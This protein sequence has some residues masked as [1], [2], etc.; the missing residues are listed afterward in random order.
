MDSR[1][2]GNPQS[3]RHST[4]RLNR[5]VALC[6]CFSMGIAGEVR[7]ADAAPAGSGAAHAATLEILEFYI[8]GNSVLDETSIDEAVEPFLGPDRTADDVD[9][10]RAALEAAY[11]DRG[12]KTVSVA[13]PRQSV[14]DG[15]IHLQV[16]EG[17]V[18][19]LDVV[20]S[21][22]HSIERI[23]EQAPALAEGG[24]PNFNDVQRDLVALNQEADRRVTPTL[25]AGA[26]PGTVDMEL[27]VDDHLPLHGLAEVNN[28]KSIGTSELRSTG[29]LSYDNLWQR[30]H[31]FSLTYQTA[32]ERQ[33]DARVLFGS[34]LAHFD[35]SPL[36]LLLNGLKTD[37]NVATLG[38]VDV[39]GK[40]ESAGI[41]GVLQLPG[42]TE[43]SPL[44][45]FGID[46]K[47]F[48][49]VT[50]LGG[51][52]I[53][54]PV[55][56][57]PISLDYSALYRG[58]SAVTQGDVS[59]TFAPRGLGSN[60]QVF[61]ANRVDSHQTAYLRANLSRAQDLPSGTQL[62][63]RLAGQLAD[64][65]L[66]SN[67]QFNVGGLDTVRGYLE[68]ETLGDYGF[69]GTIELRSRS[70]VRGPL[71]EF[72]LFA[73]V[74]GGKADSHEPAAGVHADYRLAS[75]GGGFN[76]KLYSYLNGS[77]LWADPF[78]D[79]AVTREWRSRVLF[80]VWTSF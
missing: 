12:Y 40:G 43:F 44:L 29:T 32:P 78:F 36:S 79:G 6:L 73:F 65:P 41:H 67:E 42:T 18:E 25:K 68:A 46:Y 20:N 22:Y 24:V 80:R 2:Q 1:N 5:N 26:A 7:A 28:R 39:I 63:L 35:G 51:S 70:Y 76:L 54:T 38:G 66:I 60:Q 72:Q 74:D 21:R 64:Q 69:D 57:F 3:M 17:K 47:H 27:V 8:E 4:A 56:Y 52:S 34:Y 10:A 9:H 19:H 50:M 49:S 48:R 30:G 45:T 13:I 53:N 71:Q 16:V 61:D 37:S 58:P 33:S 23:K 62:F 77:V 55:E 31:S 11:R 15:V 75:A 14:R 59:V